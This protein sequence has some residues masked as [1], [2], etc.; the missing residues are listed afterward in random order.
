MCVCGGGHSRQPATGENK[1][2]KG[3]R[4]GCEEAHW[5]TQA[6]GMGGEKRLLLRKV[7]AWVGGGG[8]VVVT[9]WRKGSTLAIEGQPGN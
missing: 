6:G 5:T 1:G 9:V 4:E 2:G 7:C 8:V 3:E